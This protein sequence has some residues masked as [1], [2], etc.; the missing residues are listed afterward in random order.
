MQIIIKQKVGN[1]WSASTYDSDKLRPDYFKQFIDTQ[2]VCEATGDTFKLYAIGQPSLM[3]KWAEN[4]AVMN[5]EDFITYLSYKVMEQA[6]GLF[7][8]PANAK[9]P[10]KKETLVVTSVSIPSSTTEQQE[11][12]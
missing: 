11:L 12:L 8:R 9:P 6:I 3:G 1:E 7:T 10:E 2:T 5:M 4:K